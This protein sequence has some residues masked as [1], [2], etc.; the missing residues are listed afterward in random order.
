MS[1]DASD[2]EQDAT[3]QKIQ[4]DEIERQI[5]ARRH[6]KAAR[7]LLKVLQDMDVKRAGLVVTDSPSI[8]PREREHQ[9]L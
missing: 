3:Q 5:F 7:L 2:N 1:H 4:L 9:Q 6:E 8:T